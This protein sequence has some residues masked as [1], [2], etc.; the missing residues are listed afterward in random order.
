MLDKLKES[1]QKFMVKFNERLLNFGRE[2]FVNAL[3]VGFFVALLSPFGFAVTT[4]ATIL[5][6]CIMVSVLNDNEHQIENFDK[7][8]FSLALF[9]CLLA[10]LMSLF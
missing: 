9:F 8:T 3:L 2:R 5:M 1:L 6:G 4:I 10:I 7:K